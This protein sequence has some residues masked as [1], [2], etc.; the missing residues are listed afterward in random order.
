MTQFKNV[1]EV[2]NLLEKSNCRKCGE[3]TCLAFSAAVYMGKKDLAECPLL[4]PEVKSQHKFQERKPNA[5]EEDSNRMI[6]KLKAEL[7]EIDFA[8]REE[9]IGATYKTGQ[10]SLKIMGKDFSI[11]REGKV[12]TNIHVNS[13]IYV[14]ILNYIIHCHGLP[15]TANWV[16]LRDLPGGLDW[17]RLFS[18]QCEKQLK[19][20]ADSYPD[21]FADLV[22]MFSGKQIVS[23]FHSDVAVILYPLPLVPMLICY[24]KPED[25]MESSLNLFFDDTAE[26]NLG[27]EALYLLGTGFALMLKKLA[28]QHGSVSDQQYS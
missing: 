14:S 15:L 20:T 1:M 5:Q 28:H 8:A 4:S 3:K 10:L 17:Y 21:L 9:L 7:Q 27:M 26:K 19:K 13:W 11:D 24:W 6:E 12:H 16:P 25:G 2:F 23:D 22:Q 18:Q